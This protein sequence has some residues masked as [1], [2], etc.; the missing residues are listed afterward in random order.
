MIDLQGFK[1][2]GKSR[3]PNQ[4]LK[5]SVTL[6]N[7]YLRIKTMADFS[8]FKIAQVFMNGP[9]VAIKFTNSDPG[10]YCHHENHI[11]KSGQ[12]ATKI[13]TMTVIKKLYG[14][15]E[16]GYIGYRSVTWKIID[17]DEDTVLFDLSTTP[18]ERR[19]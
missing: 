15:L 2:I 8:R 16:H 17:Q 5:E 10:F 3:K 12:R 11:P 14:A 13:T 7:S 18:I 6:T 4:V 1:S 9:K 19:L